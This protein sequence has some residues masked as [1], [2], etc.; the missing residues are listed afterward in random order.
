MSIS[1]VVEY[2]SFV[3]RRGSTVQRFDKMVAVKAFE[4]LIALEVVKPVSGIS[5]ATLPK[6]FQPMTMVV[7][8]SQIS[9]VLATY[10]GCPTDLQQWGSTMFV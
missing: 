7:D 2:Q 9:E 4:H 6:E 5:N 8:D 1:Y 10:H 3:A